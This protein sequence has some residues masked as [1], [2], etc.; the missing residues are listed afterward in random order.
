MN[1]IS[2]RRVKMGRFPKSS[3]AAGWVVMYGY[4]ERVQG[5]GIGV[6]KT[7]RCAVSLP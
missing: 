4:L 5:W 3:V 2:A 7:H 1:E 6:S